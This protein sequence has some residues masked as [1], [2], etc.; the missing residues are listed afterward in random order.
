MVDVTNRTNV[1]VRL[2]PRKFLFGH[3][4]LFLTTALRG[5]KARSH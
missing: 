1:A 2:R 4:T 5:R 3:D